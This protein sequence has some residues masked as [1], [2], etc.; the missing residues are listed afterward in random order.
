MKRF[1]IVLLRSAWYLAA[2]VLV[3]CATLVTLGQYYFPYLGEHKDEVLARLAATLPF[4]VRVEGL[5]AEWTGLAP[6]LYVRSLRL[7]SRDDPQ[8]TILTAGHTTLRIDLLRSLLVLEPRLRRIVAE[9]VQL[10]FVEDPDGRWHV[11]G[12]AGTGKV[13][14]PDAILDAFLAIEEVALQRTR[15]VLH[16]HGHTD[17]ETEG[18]ELALD[19]YRRFRRL[20]LRTHDGEDGGTIDLLVESHGDPREARRFSAA[21][22]LHLDRVRLARLQPVLAGVSAVPDAEVSGELWARLSTRGVITLSA[23]LQTPEIDLAMLPAL[24]ALREPLRELDLRLAAEWDG[25]RGRGSIWLDELHGKWFGEALELER[26]R[27]DV[28]H[29]DQSWRVHAGAEYLDVGSLATVVR[30]SRLLPPRLQEVLADL[31]PY[32]GLA[33]AH[34]DLRLQAGEPVDFGFRAAMNDISVSPWTNAP[35]VRNLRGYLELARGSG[36]AEIDSGAVSLEFPHLYRHDLELERVA[37]RVHWSYGDDG[38]R[39]GSRLLRASSGGSPLSALFDLG[40][41]RDPAADDYISLSFG[42]RD[43]DALAYRDYVPYIVSQ[44]LRDWLDTNIEGGRVEQ[45]AFTYHATFHRPGQPFRHALQL[46]LDVRDAALSYHPD[47]PAVR[48][49]TGRVAL[50]EDRVRVELDRGRM[51]QS[52]LGPARVEVLPRHDDGRVRLAADLDGRFADGL[53]VVNASP[54]ARA[55][56]GAL[57]DWKGSGRMTLRLDLDLPLDEPPDSP[58]S[59]VDVGVTIDGARLFVAEPGLQFE[60]VHG[61]V[62]FDLVRGLASNRIDAM[63]WGQPVRARIAM[64]E[65][66]ER[67]TRIAVSGNT[68]ISRVMSW[69]NWDLDGRLSGIAPFTV[70][71]TQ[72]QEHGFGFLL[73]S[74]LRG[75]RSALPAPLAKTPDQEWPLELRWTGVADGADIDLALGDGIRGELH[76]N[77]AGR[78]SGGI[79]F[80]GEVLTGQLDLLISGSAAEADLAEWI[81]AV[82]A[83]ADANGERGNPGGTELRL[84]DVELGSAT[85]F[86]ARLNGVRLD[87][88]RNEDAQVFEFAADALAGSFRMPAERGDPLALDL[89]RLQL[90]VFLGGVQ[91]AQDSDA[92]E[93]H[94]GLPIGDADAWSGLREVYVPPTDIHARH[95][96]LDEREL[97]EWWLRLASQTDALVLS[98]VRAVLPGGRIGGR[99]GE[100]DA[101]ARLRWVAGAPQSELL[102]GLSSD[103]IGGL[104]KNWGY[105]DVLEAR[106]TRADVEL[107]WAGN[108]VDFA[109]EHVEGSVAF[110]SRD[111][112]LLRA[113]GSNPVLRTLGVLNLDEVMRRI[114]LDFK[115]LYQSGLTFDTFAG[116]IDLEKGMARTR[117]PV[118]L[119]GPSTRI[120]FAGALDLEAK[121]VDADLTVTL[122]IGSNLPWMAALAGGLPAA[123]GAYV[124]SRVFESQLGKYSSAIYKVSGRFDNPDVEFVK[125]FDTEDQTRERTPPPAAAVTSTGTSEQAPPA[126]APSGE[127]AP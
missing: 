90:R 5:T 83:I 28:R 14:N 102:F 7:Q 65:D 93:R 97:G 88:H 81:A 99:R 51:L 10:A 26:M 113:S 71:V 74:P 53:R 120:R 126:Q 108:P 22:Y 34:L 48:E 39:V 23:A 11:A 118:V 42:L 20:R 68:D 76:R 59:R 96:Q 17:I 54:L 37:G 95:V 40:L 75:I 62:S 110:A 33:N 100:G 18:A 109:I 121:Q 79:A 46:A 106:R 58:G 13:S 35:G 114:R 125:V 107:R 32:G 92:P 21:G 94:P 72:Q 57:K 24:S 69:L 45:A 15:L 70:D 38:V 85:L 27:I 9:D 8:Q 105:E 41:R 84:Q 25:G 52:T 77:R 66:G 91:E 87:S 56:G 55:T 112:R 2:G 73:R 123:A 101:S 3:L 116:A 119:E 6:T 63:L 124:A 127:V 29:R 67:H 12:A 50:D 104:L 89:D 80:G 16:P 1:S 82:R 47:W 60:D 4:E 44:Q 49:A 78:L 111:G 19:N 36:V 61:D 98:D 115:D 117:D 122:P 31:A 43:A 64:T 30:G 86:G 103:D